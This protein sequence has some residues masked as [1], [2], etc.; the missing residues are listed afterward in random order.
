M[1]PCHGKLLTRANAAFY[2]TLSKTE[3]DLTQHTLTLRKNEDENRE[4]APAEASEDALVGEVPL[5]LVSGIVARNNESYPNWCS[6]FTPYLVS[7][8]S[9]KSL[10]A[11]CVL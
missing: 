7:K 11:I 10:Q 6:E 4:I 2:M 9:L 3:G 5:A 1:N 8:V